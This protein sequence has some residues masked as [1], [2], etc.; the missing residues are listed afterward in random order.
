[1]KTKLTSILVV[2]MLSIGIAVAAEGQQKPLTNQDVIRMIEEKLPES[3][4]IS[5]IQ[6]SETK[7]DTSPAAISELNKKGVSEKV[8][9]A[10]VNANKPVQSPAPAIP[11]GGHPVVPMVWMAG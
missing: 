8:L 2:A 9:N 1:M 4:I 3:V 10:M 11:P 6:T 5:K 7:F